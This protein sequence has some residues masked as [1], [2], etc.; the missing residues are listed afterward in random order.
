LNQTVNVQPNK[1]KNVKLPVSRENWAEKNSENNRFWIEKEKRESFGF[2]FGEKE[3]VRGI[4][5]DKRGFLGFNLEKKNKTNG[6]LMSFNLGFSWKL[7][8][9]KFWSHV[10]VVKYKG[11][12]RKEVKFD[13]FGGRGR[14]KSW[15]LN[16]GK[17]WS[18]MKV[19]K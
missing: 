10:K 15:K 12:I 18:H 9:G 5:G 14:V 8:G 13:Y 19:V 2:W 3:R 1:K 11:R 4:E 17:F 6:N 16:G 7:D